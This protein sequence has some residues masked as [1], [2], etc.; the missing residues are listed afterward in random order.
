VIATARAAAEAAGALVAGA[1]GADVAYFVGRLGPR[2]A[3][4]STTPEVVVAA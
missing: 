1:S 2:V 4:P 3:S